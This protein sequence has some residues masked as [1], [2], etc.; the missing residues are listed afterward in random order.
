M[1]TE[2]IRKLE[3]EYKQAQV[4]YDFNLQQVRYHLYQL[5]LCRVKV[6]EA[7]EKYFDA[8]SES[9][10]PDPDEERARIHRLLIQESSRDG[11]V[12]GLED[13]EMLQERVSQRKAEAFHQD[14][15]RKYREK[16]QAE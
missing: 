3:H 7:Q 1:S 8:L 9:D 4:Q 5:S 12:Y 11:R 16:Q 6:N 2:E 14:M 15:L 10:L 13:V